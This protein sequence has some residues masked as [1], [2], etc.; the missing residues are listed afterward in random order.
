MIKIIQVIGV[1]KDMIMESPYE[2]VKPTVFF[3]NPDWANI[4]TVSIKPGIPVRGCIK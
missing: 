1:I 4:I 3:Y 2:P